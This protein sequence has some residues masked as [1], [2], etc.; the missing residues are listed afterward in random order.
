MSADY[1]SCMVSSLR[2]LPRASKALATIPF[3]S[4][5]ACAYIVA[6]E[7]VID[8]CVGQNHRTHFQAAV[9]RTVL[10]KRLHHERSEAANRAFLDGDQHFMVLGQTQQQI[11]VERLGETCVRHRGRQAVRSKRFRCLHALGE[12]CAVGEQRHRIA[13]AQHATFTDFERRAE[14]RQVDAHTVTARITQ[15]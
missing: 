15:C 5:P 1:A 3:A 10:G 13:F 12:T 9:E 4:R 7:I 2:S 8:E 14:F 11:D 6:G